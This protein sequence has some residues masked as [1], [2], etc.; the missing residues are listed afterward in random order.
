[1][2]LVLGLGNPGERYA[3]T[4]HNVAWRVLDELAAAPRRDAGRGVP[5]VPDAPGPL[6]RGRRGV[7]DAADV[8]ERERRGIAWSGGVRHGMDPADAAGGDG[9]RVPAARRAAVARRTDPAAD[10]GASRASRRRW[11][12]GTTRGCASGWGPRPEARRSGNTCWRSSHR[13]S[14]RCWKT[15]VRLAADA[16]ECWVARGHP[17]CHESVQSQGAQGG[18]G[19][20]T[21]YETVFVLDP[22]FDEVKAGEEADRVS[23]WIKDL[24]RRG[25]RGAE[26]GQASPRLRDPQEARRRLHDDRVERRRRHGEGD[27]APAAPERERHARADDACTSRRSCRR[28]CRRAKRWRRATTGTTTSDPTSPRG[29]AMSELRSRRSTGSR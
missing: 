16:V 15:A 21:K 20:V 17:G 22:S 24:A 3:R 23:G 29:G 4:R 9:R 19:V 25:G 26:V 7:A 28:A 1:M 12:R 13:R 5:G 11:A 10:T 8:H 18:S 6:R 2:R 27:R 14:C